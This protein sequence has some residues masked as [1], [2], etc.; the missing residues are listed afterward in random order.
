M[1]DKIGS[2]L[3]SVMVGLDSKVLKDRNRC[4]AIIKD[5]LPENKLE[6]NILIIALEMEVVHR[7]LDKPSN[8]PGDILLPQLARILTDNAGMSDDK[9][10]WAVNIWSFALGITKI[11]YELP[12][13]QPASTKTSQQTSQP[14]KSNPVKS[15][16]NFSL[17]SNS[18]TSASVSLFND[19]LHLLE[20]GGLDEKV[21]LLQEIA[22]GKLKINIEV[23]QLITRLIKDG[24]LGVRFWSKKAFTKYQQ[25]FKVDHEKSLEP[26]DNKDFKIEQLLAKLESAKSSSFISLDTIKKL[27]ETKDSRVIAPLLDYLGQCKDVIQISYIT[28]LLGVCFPSDEILQ[29]LEP[30]LSHND[31]RVVA[32]TIEGIEAIGTMASVK[33]IGSSLNPTNN[34]VKANAAKALARFD[35]DLAT[36]AIVEM[37]QDS[38]NPHNQISAC[39]AV[40]HLKSDIFIG[41]LE[42]MMENNIL[43]S[44]VIAAL[45]VI[46]GQYVADLFVTSYNTSD[47]PHR[48]IEF[49]NALRL[50]KDSVD[51]PAEIPL[52][53]EE[54]AVQEEETTLDDQQ[55]EPPP[56]TVRKM[57]NYLS[58]FIKS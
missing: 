3:A 13:S 48:K 17:K 11:V 16:S 39:Y 31:E 9:A 52:Q 51:I 10:H 53:E 57:I 49:L 8:M 5:L 37:L 42:P 33:L 20:F 23:F 21:K 34:R 4:K 7:L 2:I 19:T 47:E 40:K 54:E 41:Y 6:A 44:D 22:Q 43:L 26:R 27:F 24:D 35:R 46:G 18:M 25:Q 36:T 58:G 1:S 30:Y 28:K 45:T 38:Q 29:H 50:M 55:E 14:I 32:N 15:N 12:I 56:G